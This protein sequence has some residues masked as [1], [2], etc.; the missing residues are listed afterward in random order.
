MN[1]K[2]I[3]A[4][5][6]ASIM[7]LSLCACNKENNTS[8]TNLSSDITTIESDNTE[9]TESDTESNVLTDTDVTD[10]TEITSNNSVSDTSE[11]SNN[12]S[13]PSSSATNN[14]KP[15]TSINT[16][17]TGSNNDN[18]NNNTPSNNVCS[19]PDTEIRG[20]I[21]PTTTATGY[22]GDTYCKTCDVKTA[23]GASIPKLKNDNDGK[24]TYTT[25]NGYTY[26]VDK[27]VD[28]TEY[29]MALKTKKI[30]SPYRE[31]E[32]E[33]LRL[34]NEER[35]KV[36]LKPLEWYEDAYYFTH[37]R[38]EEIY[39][40]W[41]HQRPDWSQWHTVYTDAGVILHCAYGE[42]LARFQGFPANK[43]VAVAAVTGWMESEGHRANIL[44]P[45]YTKMTVSLE[46]GSDNFTLCAVQHFFGDTDN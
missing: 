4:L 36:G 21:E 10:T 1:M 7:L 23:N 43:E 14:L 13:K 40:Q 25:S 6:L 45:N 11:S 12:T 38:A 9:T 8:D 44:N 24:V 33:I 27:D 42:N 28:I 32:L 16:S 5:L 31:A 17:N 22:T 3:L 15:T 18:S 2:R 29:T 35:A 46:F 41:G 39:I 34:C 19:H 26:V 20:R 37:I 30:N